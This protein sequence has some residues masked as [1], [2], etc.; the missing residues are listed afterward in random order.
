[1]VYVVF[2]KDKKRL[3]KCKG[4]LWS[5]L[6]EDGGIFYAQKALEDGKREFLGRKIEQVVSCI[7][8][9]FID[10]IGYAS[11]FQDDRLLWYSSRVASK[12]F[13]Q[14]FMFHQYAY[15]KLIE[16]YAVLDKDHL[17][18]VNDLTLW[19][20]L[21][22]FK[23]HG[24]KIYAHIIA[25]FPGRRLL[26]K[27]Q[28]NCQFFLRL[29]YWVIFKFCLPAPEAGKYD[30]I[31]HSFIDSRVFSRLPEYTDAYFGNLE[32]VLKKQGSRVLRITPLSVGL[33]SA[34][35]LKKYFRNITFLLSYL[36]LSDFYRIFFTRMC[37]K[38][39]VPEKEGIKDIKL[40]NILLKQEEGFENG[41][42]DFQSNLFYY[43]AFRNFAKQFPVGASII[44]TFENQP[45][46][47]MLNLA[48]GNDFK[49]IAYQHTIISANWLDYRTSAFEKQAPLPDIILSSGQAW[50]DFLRKYY[51]ACPLEEA[52]AIRLNY[53]F[54][55]PQRNDNKKSKKIVTALPI[56]PGI[57]VAL[58]KNLLD[59]LASGKFNEYD[60]V[61][62]SHPYLPRSA[63]LLKEFLRYGN[64]QVSPS[65]L[66]ELLGDCALLV[67]SGSTAA[68]EALSLGVKA[69]C[70]IPETVAI[71]SEYFIRNHLEF[72]F[73]GDFREKL[74]YCLRNPVTPTG[75]KVEEFFSPPD[76]SVFLR[77]LQ[78]VG[79]VKNYT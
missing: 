63:L 57:A 26:K 40:L 39:E 30:V 18:I 13:S 1:M 24:V 69:L 65:S 33:R 25:D 12:S 62:K 2:A 58:Q 54:S 50:F 15:L 23:L 29:I 68:F 11:T 16:S 42:K 52:G 4:M 73:S 77:H 70:F 34:I 64:C 37:I 9:N 8:D 53:L 47:K 56:L 74:L 78:S 19:G 61:I 44:Y 75:F 55:S 76:Y 28:A 45:W 22:L 38:S 20:S 48:F 6:G 71:E 3:S 60:F 27:I 49:K 46:E 14:M 59:C 41:D 10:Y 21:K 35:K 31:L 32:V 66:K 7:R 79:R 43:Y 51:G 17:F 36:K 72:A 5:Y 67:T